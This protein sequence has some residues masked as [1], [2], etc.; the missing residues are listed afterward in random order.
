MNAR[1]LAFAGEDVAASGPLLWIDASAP[2]SRSPILQLQGRHGREGTYPL[3]EKDIDGAHVDLD[4]RG[5]RADEV[6]YSRVKASPERKAC[7]HRRLAQDR[8]YTQKM[9][10]PGEPAIPSSPALYKEKGGE[11]TGLALLREECDTGPAAA[12]RFRPGRIGRGSA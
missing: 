9:S 7:G 1:N 4:R 3:M 12:G 2:R 8:G 6:V 10:S 11:V 5:T